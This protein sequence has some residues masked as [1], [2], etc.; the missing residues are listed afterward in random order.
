MAVSFLHM[1]IGII[2]IGIIGLLIIVGTRKVYLTIRVTRLKKKLADSV[3]DVRKSAAQADSDL[4]IHKSAAQ[5]LGKIGPKARQAIP[6]LIKVM[7]VPRGGNIAAE[8]LEKIDPQWRE[9]PEAKQAIPDLI[10][11]L[12]DF[13]AWDFH[14]CICVAMVL[15]DIGKPV[16]PDLVKALSSGA[17]QHAAGAIGDIGPEAKQAIPDLVKVLNDPKSDIRIYA[18]K[19]LGR[20][21]P[22]AKQAMPDLIKSMVNRNENIYIYAAEALEKIDSQWRESLEAKQAKL[23]LIMTLNDWNSQ[24]EKVLEEIDPQWWESPEA[25][26]AIPDLIMTLNDWNSCAEKALEEIDPQ[27]RERPEVKQVIPDLVKSLHTVRLEKIDPQWQERPEVKQ[28]ILDLV[29]DMHDSNTGVRSGAAIALGRIGTEARQ[30][31]PVL[32]KA[33]NDSNSDVRQRAAG[34]LG[35]IGPEAKQAI[36]VLIKDLNDSNSDVRQHA[37]GALGRIGPE[38]KQAIPDLIQ[39]FS[40]S[41]DIIT[42]LYAAYALGNIGPE[43]RQAVPVLIEFLNDTD[44]REHAVEALEKIDPRWQEKTEAK[45]TVIGKLMSIGGWVHPDYSLEYFEV[46]NPGDLLCSDN[47][48]PSPKT[49]ILSGKSYLYIS[50]EI[51]KWRQNAKTFEEANKKIKAMQN[52]HNFTLIDPRVFD[53]T[54][55]CEECAKRHKLNLD[56]A[57]ADAEYWSRTHLAYMKLQILLE[58]FFLLSCY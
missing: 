6:E 11:T 8:A 1:V 57:A 30:A 39:V 58:F 4:N 14:V 34:A 18:A 19:A 29:K 13:D 22:E 52:P 7:P 16:I 21:G 53:P 45:Q 25:K 24:A 48:C 49:T 9:S 10:K 37:A 50:E 2:C 32:I 55:L 23:D 20:I 38:A 36:P 33:L 44:V 31:I 17:R 46:L 42:R 51:V 56:I 43:A 12:E 28:V 26:Q 40:D 35:S 5:A 3:L 41:R 27:W 47:A 54:L 15:T